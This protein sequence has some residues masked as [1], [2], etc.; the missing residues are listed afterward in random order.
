MYMCMHALITNHV[1][2]LASVSATLLRSLNPCYG[3]KCTRECLIV[4][5]VVVLGCHDIQ[6]GRLDRLH[7]EVEISTGFTHRGREARGCVNHVETEPSDVTDLHHE[8]RSPDN[9]STA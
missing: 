9:V 3:R 6:Y 8:L 4:L 2:L 7:H 1:D 5:L